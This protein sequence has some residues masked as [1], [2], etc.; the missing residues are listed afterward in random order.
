MHFLLT[1]VTLV[2]HTCKHL[3][4]FILNLFS[5]LPIHT[6]RHKHSAITLNWGF[7][8]CKCQVISVVQSPPVELD[9]V[10][11][12]R[13]TVITLHRALF[14][15]VAIFVLCPSLSSDLIQNFV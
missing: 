8:L 9:H 1:S 3:L 5:F 6:H 13:L 11:N 7:S 2:A 4:S 15:P 14:F 10:K 12:N